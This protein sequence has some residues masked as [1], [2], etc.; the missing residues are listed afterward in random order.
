MTYLDLLLSKVNVVHYLGSLCL[1]WLG[2]SQVCRFQYS[3]VL[4]TDQEVSMSTMVL[5]S[6]Q[7]H[8]V[9]LRFA[10]W[11]ATESSLNKACTSLLERD[12]IVGDRDASFVSDLVFATL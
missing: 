11:P 1:V 4:G 2:V 7:T 10:L 5:Y 6:G 8:L 9:L 3:M 12:L